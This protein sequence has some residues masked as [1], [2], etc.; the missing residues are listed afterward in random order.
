VGVEEEGADEKGWIPESKRV[1]LSHIAMDAQARR[2]RLQ[3]SSSGAV[4]AERVV[5]G[6]SLV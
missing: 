4:V 6:T 5:R 2:V 1:R 3:C